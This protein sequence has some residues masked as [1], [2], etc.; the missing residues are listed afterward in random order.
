ML[1]N[2]AKTS[3]HFH[4][5]SVADLKEAVQVM[6]DVQLGKRLPEADATA[7]VAFLEALTGEVPAHYA[8]PKK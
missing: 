6:A 8:P 4:D 3:P 7:I 1:R 5:G 2:I